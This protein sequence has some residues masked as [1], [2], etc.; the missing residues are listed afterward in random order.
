VFEHH[1]RVGP[2]TTPLITAIHTSATQLFAGDELG[3]L[4][5]AQHTRV[6]LSKPWLTLLLLPSLVLPWRR[7]PCARLLLGLVHGSVR[8][9]LRCARSEAHLREL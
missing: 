3:R 8:Q 7:D 9:A 2:A 5:G 4:Y 6:S 1:D